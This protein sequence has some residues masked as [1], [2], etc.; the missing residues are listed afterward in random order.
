MNGKSPWRCVSC[1]NI[2]WKNPRCCTGILIL[3]KSNILLVKRKISPWKDYWDIQGGYCEANESLEECALREAQEEIGKTIKIES[4]WKSYNYKI[5]SE[6]YGD[7]ICIFFLASIEEFEDVSDFKENNEISSVKWFDLKHLPYN[8][9]F[10]Q[11][12][13]RVLKEILLIEGYERKEENSGT[14]GN[15][16]G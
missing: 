13:K 12:T 3:K 16:I 8:I 11:T 1:G 7:N 5:N 15:Y 6:F 9:A 4:L 10:P 2:V 14:K